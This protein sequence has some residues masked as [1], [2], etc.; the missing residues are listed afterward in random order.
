MMLLPSP[1][2]L[3]L[4]WCPAACCSAVLPADVL[5][6][7]YPNVG[8]CFAA[9]TL[10]RL[11]S[12][13]TVAAEQIV[14][15]EELMG[16][17][18]CA[19]VVLPGSLSRGHAPLFRIQPLHSAQSAFSVNGSHILVLRVTCRPHKRRTADGWDVCCYELQTD[20]EMRRCLR[21]FSEETAADAELQLQLSRWSGPLE[22]EV[23]VDDFRTS[24]Q[25]VQSV[26]LLVSSPVVTFAPKAHRSLQS[27]LSELGQPADAEQCDWA[28]WYLGLSL[29]ASGNGALHAEAVRSRLR[30]GLHRLG[31]AACSL[32]QLYGVDT[33]HGVAP[34]AWLLESERVRSLMLAGIMDAHRNHQVEQPLLPS[35]RYQFTARR[36]DTLAAFAL[37]AASLGISSTDIRGETLGQ[38]EEDADFSLSSRSS[39][40]LG[41]SGDIDRIAQLS[42]SAVVRDVK[43]ADGSELDSR[44]V[45][46]SI[47]AEAEAEYWGFAVSGTNARFLLADFTVTH[48][49]S[50]LR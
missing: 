45:R 15:G 42:A 47:T 21:W 44:C 32:L 46:F 19:R 40:W 31:R 10:L 48:N 5:V 41:M 23:S 20:N 13:S 18:G 7:G 12:G 2:R 1:L 36:R 8:K 22:W 38:H 6:V 50:R 25:H 37:L 28:A 14:G 35:S 27:T 39:L 29:A 9:G 30:E 49:V 43:V 3:D 26:C 4:T 33:S 11:Y 24:P 16:D 34:P 17:D